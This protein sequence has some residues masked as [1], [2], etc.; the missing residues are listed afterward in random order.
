MS[1][2]SSAVAASRPV[3]QLGER[4]NTET[5]AVTNR[6]QK[7]HQQRTHATPAVRPSPAVVETV[8]NTGV[9]LDVWRVE[10]DML[11]M[12]IED[13]QTRSLQKRQE[14]LQLAIALAGEQHIVL[15][16]HRKSQKACGMVQRDET[17]LQVQAQ[18]RVVPEPALEEG[19]RNQG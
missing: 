1:G 7:I 18:V 2:D 9:P 11:R 17:R 13:L 6:A 12:K 16:E 15:E 8:A 19:R 5:G 14:R 3:E 4:K 10:R